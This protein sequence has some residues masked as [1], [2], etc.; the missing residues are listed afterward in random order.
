MTNKKK[1][2][3]C[4]QQDSKSSETESI[5]FEDIQGQDNLLK[6]KIYRDGKIHEIIVLAISED[7]FNSNHEV[8]PPPLVSNLQAMQ[9]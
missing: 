8:T 7:D 6:A 1:N 3:S 5:S 9:F 4:L 2:P